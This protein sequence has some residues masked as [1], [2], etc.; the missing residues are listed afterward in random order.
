[1]EDLGLYGGDN[2][3]LDL[4][5]HRDHSHDSRTTKWKKLTSEE[6]NGL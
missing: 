5:G 4:Q 2:I 1:L 6:P 3:K